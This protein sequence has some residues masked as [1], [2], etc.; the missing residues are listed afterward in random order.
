[1]TARR[2]IRCHGLP[3]DL[4]DSRE[5]LKGRRAEDAVAVA[6]GLASVLGPVFATRRAYAKLLAGDDRHACAAFLRRAYAWYGEQGIVIERLLSA[7]RL[8][9]NQALAAV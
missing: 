6:L 5:S 9:Q 8:G 7:T 3:G 4:R 1:M 2:E